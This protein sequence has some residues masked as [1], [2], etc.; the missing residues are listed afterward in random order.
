MKNQL[1]FKYLAGIPLWIVL[2]VLLLIGNLLAGFNGLYGQDSFEYLRYS[3]ALHHY[4]SAGVLPGP[5]H[6][7]LF[8]P[9]SGALLSFILPGCSCLAGYKYCKLR[10]ADIFSSENNRA[11]LS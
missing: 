4:L 9:L 7:P 6:W 8:Y 11:S 5:F 2:P 10:T 3:R 1:F